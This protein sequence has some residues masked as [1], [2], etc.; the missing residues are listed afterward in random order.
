MRLIELYILRR[1]VALSIPTLAVI[2][3]V[4]I[5]SQLMLNIDMLTRSTQAAIG[6]LRLMGNLVLPMTMIVMPFGIL[7][8]ALRTL[9]GMNADAELSVLE[10][11][12]RAPR[13]TTRPII[14]FGALASLLTLGLAHTLEPISNLNLLEAFRVARADIV[15]SSVR[16]GSFARLG[17]TAFIQVGHELP[18]GQMANVVMVD[19]SDPLTQVLYYAKRG[20]LIEHQGSTL[21]ALANGEVHRQNRN[22][23][24]VSVIAFDSTAIDLGLSSGAG[25]DYSWQARP[26]RELIDAVFGAGVP[27]P[28]A[29]IEFHRRMTDWFYPLLFAIV[30]AC[31]AGKAKTSRQNTALG[32]GLGLA[33]AFSLRA[34]GFITVGNSG[35]S[36][37][38]AVLSYAMPISAIAIGFVIATFSGTNRV[39][40]TAHWI[41]SKYFQSRPKDPRV[42]T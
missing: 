19:D 23:G 21:F 40:R 4:V 2:S 12:G 31:I 35:T 33:A 16:S 30:A 5:T 1:V 41:A 8:G 10:A 39:A 24:H 26:T 34:A 18:N 6:F 28:D 25:I 17:D 14:L 9:N 22:T 13:A 11:T 7:F 42:A 32:F 15:R 38:Q 37:F 27:P 36:S 20:D 3:G 29:S